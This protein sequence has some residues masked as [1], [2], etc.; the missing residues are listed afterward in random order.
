[1]ELLLDNGFCSFNKDWNGRRVGEI[2]GRKPSRKHTMASQDVE[3]GGMVSCVIRQRNAPTHVHACMR[4]Q[5]QLCIL[6]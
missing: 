5:K 4:A 6:I 3:G 1:M 2:G